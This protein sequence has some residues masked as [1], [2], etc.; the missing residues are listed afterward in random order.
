VLVVLVLVPISCY[1][2]SFSVAGPIFLSRAGVRIRFCFFD[3]VPHQV[4]CVSFQFSCRSRSSVHTPGVRV[5]TSKSAPVRFCR[6]FFFG[7]C[8]DFF[9]AFSLLPARS[10]ARRASGPK[11]VAQI[12][13]A[14][15]VRSALFSHR[16][17][18]VSLLLHF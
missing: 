14:Q 10:E 8:C 1:C 15:A 9:S 2:W 13:S 6:R 12:L 16:R 7:S 11:C 3:S 18:S 17:S 5:R 4:L